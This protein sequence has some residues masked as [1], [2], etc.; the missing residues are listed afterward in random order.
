[1]AAFNEFPLQ[2]PKS[3]FPILR[4]DLGHRLPGQTLNLVVAVQRLASE[5]RRNG[6]TVID[7]PVPMKP[8]GRD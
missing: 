5:M 7:L 2:H 8:P 3:R 6:A 1:M 4:K